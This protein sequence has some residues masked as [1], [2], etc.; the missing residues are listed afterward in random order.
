MGRV[1]LEQR[2][3]HCGDGQPHQFR[4]RVSR[5]CFCCLIPEH[6]IALAVQQRGAF[7]KAIQRGFKKFRPIRHSGPQFLPSARHGPTSP[8]CQVEKRLELANGNASK[9]RKLSGLIPVLTSPTEISWLFG[10]AGCSLICR[11][12]GRVKSSSILNRSRKSPPPA[13]CVPDSDRSRILRGTA[14]NPARGKSGRRTL[15]GRVVFA[16]NRERVVC[17]PVQLGLAVR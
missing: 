13:P 10:F 7:W 17:N 1:P 2:L 12:N 15:N 5:N 6:N 16:D 9:P 8:S 4:A 14:D 3:E 11:K